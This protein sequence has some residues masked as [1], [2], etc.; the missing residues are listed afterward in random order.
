MAI[1]KGGKGRDDSFTGTDASDRFEFDPADLT[2][3][4]R[5]VGGNGGA[6]DILAFTAGGAIS[7]TA[8]AGVS[9]IEQI[10]LNAAGNA[11]SLVAGL[12]A[13]ASDNEVTVVGG[14]GN[15]VIDASGISEAAGAA[16]TL[17]FQGGAG[18]DVITGVSGGSD[19]F[20][21]VYQT[22]DGGAG[23]DT[24]DLSQASFRTQ[25]FYD[26]E[27][28][29]LALTRGTLFVR[30]RAA[31]DLSQN[32]DQS[33]NDRVI[34]TGVDDVDASAS[35]QAVRLTGGFASYLIGGSGDD[36]LIGGASMTGG[37]GADT[38]FMRSSFSNSVYLAAGDFE[39]GERIFGETERDALSVT[40]SVDLRKGTV[41]GIEELS[42]A[43]AAG[44][45]VAVVTLDLA[46]AQ[47]LQS[48]ASFDNKS[49]VRLILTDDQD[50]APTFLSLQG[51]TLDIY[52]SDGDNVI[53]G[54][55]H[56]SGG[57]GDDTITSGGD[58]RGGDGDDAIGYYAPGGSSMQL[59]DGGAGTDTLTWF[60]AFVP[61]G[62]VVTID[63]AARDQTRNDNTR[64]RG[65]ENLDFSASQYDAVNATGDARDNVLRG[66]QQDDVLNGGIGDDVLRGGAGYDRM[67]GGRGADIFEWT[68]VE[69]SHPIETIDFKP[70]EDR[71]AFDSQVFD[72]TGSKF[73][74]LVVTTGDARTVISGADVIVIDGN[75]TA[76]SFLSQA[77]G[78]KVGE[79]VFVVEADGHGHAILYHAVDASFS[80]SQQLDAI[81]QFKL[82]DPTQLQ[83]SDFAFI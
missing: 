74:K 19:G 43:A 49:T 56:V 13:T 25:A 47:S 83:L 15:D 62:Q 65:F 46:G 18:D 82:A 30:G 52:G 31:I 29:K 55:T 16:G 37:K 39:A 73:D 40:G 6:V 45:K 14:A 66:T 60:Y 75:G 20:H 58:V 77:R 44:A 63:F 81:A 48:I 24:I 64:V 27:D 41:R 69:G 67:T 26:P 61:S 79:G 59:A 53:R 80:Q 33:L 70:G 35:S 22:A 8:L 50:F 9:G 42:V 1:F 38:F 11:I 12:L 34:L 54:G 3:A 32:G 51:V 5:I 7:S 10:E 72:I 57:A 68:A 78:G 21:N 71:L 2:A 76:R 36:V 23:A 4:D 17:L 28:V